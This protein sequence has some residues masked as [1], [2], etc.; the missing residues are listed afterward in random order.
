MK[1]EFSKTN[2]NGEKTGSVLQFCKSLQ[3]LTTENKFSHLLLHPVFGHVLF[4]LKY[5]KETQPQI[6]NVVKKGRIS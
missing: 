2:S 1:N 4:W 6:D 5:V 3:C